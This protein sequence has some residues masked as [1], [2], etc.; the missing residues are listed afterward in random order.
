[1]IYTV[2]DIETNGLRRNGKSP[3]V[4]EVGYIQINEHQRLLRS[5]AFYFYKHEWTLQKDASRVHGLSKE[6]L[7][8]FEAEYVNSLVKLWT[9][10]EHGMLI[11]KNSDAFDI[12]VCRDM[13]ASG[14][15][16]L[17]LP[18]VSRSIDV[19]KIWASVYRELIQQHTGKVVKNAGTLEE[20]TTLLGWQ[21]KDMELAFNELFPG[22]EQRCRA[23]GA[24]YD[25]FAT[26]LVTKDAVKRGL[27]DLEA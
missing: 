27:L 20:Y 26:L 11:G 24:L 4:L 18:Y 14:E 17:G 10:M 3:E 19:Q 16:N 1:M 15:G 21:T 23:H 9:L 2:F 13:F 7:E 6:F 22:N 25:A 12:P 8:Q 5:G